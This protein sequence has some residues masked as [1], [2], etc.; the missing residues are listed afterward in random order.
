MHPFIVYN[1]IVK[2]KKYFTEWFKHH[3]NLSGNF[4]L[5]LKESKYTVIIASPFP[6]TPSFPAIDNY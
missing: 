1:S 6:N 2:K 5:P 4:L 3:H